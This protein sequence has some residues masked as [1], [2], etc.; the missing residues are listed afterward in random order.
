MK[1]YAEEKEMYIS[2]PRR[3]MS[4]RFWCSIIAA[5]LNC[6]V[7]QAEAHCHQAKL[8]MGSSPPSTLPPQAEKSFRPD[9]NHTST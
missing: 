2:V 9:Y 1:G 6:I 4:V 5:R 3:Q 8:T 7:S